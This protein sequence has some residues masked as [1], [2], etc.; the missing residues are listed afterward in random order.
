MTPYPAFP[1]GCFLGLAFLVAAAGPGTADTALDHISQIRQLIAEGRNSSAMEAIQKSLP[2]SEH[3]PELRFLQGIVHE[4][5]GNRKAAIRIYQALI[6]EYP[7]HPAPYNN[8]AV[9]HAYDGN[10]KAAV[11]VLERALGTSDDYRTVYANLA[12]IYEKLA[13]DA[14]L[15]ALDSSEDPVPPR[16]TYISEMEAEATMPPVLQERNPGN[17]RPGIHALPA[18]ESTAPDESPNAR[19]DRRQKNH[20]RPGASRRTDT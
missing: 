8:L 18:G 9:L 16:L 19:H 12:S 14:Y 10:F 7:E 20:R 1:L 4:N 2:T 3:G 11:S 6:R 17:P 5:L 15:K 13:R